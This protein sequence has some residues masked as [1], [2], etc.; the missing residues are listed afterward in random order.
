MITRAG[1][2]PAPNI[3]IDSQEGSRHQRSALH[4]MSCSV[5]SSLAI[6]LVIL[7][8]VFCTPSATAD[9]LVCKQLLIKRWVSPDGQYDGFI[10]KGIDCLGLDCCGC[11]ALGDD[12]NTVE[13]TPYPIPGTYD[14]QFVVKMS[15]CCVVPIA[16][17]SI[18]ETQDA[19]ELKPDPERCDPGS[20]LACAEYGADCLGDPDE[21]CGNDALRCY[22][23][24]PFGYKVFHGAPL[25][26]DVSGDTRFFYWSRGSLGIFVTASP[27]GA[28]LTACELPKKMTFTFPAPEDCD[29]CDGE[30]QTIDV[31]LVWDPSACPCESTCS[32]ATQDCSGDGGGGSGPGSG[33][34]GGP[35]APVPPTMHPLPVIRAGNASFSPSL[36]GQI[37]YE[38]RVVA[39]SDAFGG[40]DIAYLYRIPGL[41]VVYDDLDHVFVQHNGPNNITGNIYELQ[42]RVLVKATQMEYV[43]NNTRTGVGSEYSLINGWT[44][45]RLNLSEIRLIGEDSSVLTK[46]RA[47]EAQLASGE[48]APSSWQDASSSSIYLNFEY[49]SNSL[50]TQ[51]EAH[52]GQVM[53]L[54]YDEVLYGPMGNESTRYN[55]A[56]ISNSCESCPS[57]TYEFDSELLTKVKDADSTTIAA[58]DYASYTQISYPVLTKAYRAIGTTN[59]NMYDAVYDVTGNKI[60]HY[61]YQTATNKQAVVDEFDG[62]LGGLTKRS[63]Y[64]TT[65]TGAPSGSADVINYYYNYSDDN[66]LSMEAAMP[67]DN[68]H[69]WLLPGTDDGI[70]QVT[71]YFVSDGGSN[72]ITMAS[73]GFGSL[74]ENIEAPVLSMTDVR[75]SQTI[76]EYDE[77]PNL[78]LTKTIDPQVSTVMGNVRH[79]TDYAYDNQ[80]RLTRIARRTTNGSFTYTD[81][82]YDG[83]DRA[84]LSIQDSGGENLTTAYTYDSAGRLRTAQDPRGVRRV[85]SYSTAGSLARQYTL[86][87]GSSD[88]LELTI[89]DYD[90]LGRLTRQRIAKSDGTISSPESYSGDAITTQFSY[91]VYGRR[92]GVVTDSGGLNLTT[93]Y[94]YDNLDRVVKTTTPGGIF[95][96]IDRDGRGR[97]IRQIVGATGGNS[98]TTGYEYDA[99]SNLTRVSEPSG[100]VMTYDYDGFDRRT[101]ATRSAS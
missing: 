61:N 84:T 42:N 87:T 1:Q 50:L 33:G 71:K 68:T 82:L 60:T 13:P 54:E 73:Y 46:V 80:Y 9:D 55:L 39:F 89:Y 18:I 28:E 37:P 75:G 98:L 11:D 40:Y 17:T 66:L 57:Y 74:W 41:G 56:S 63:Y 96:Q 91:D 58:Y 19:D 76:Y 83:F 31:E 53:T 69:K 3:V 77:S 95:T 49:D 32:A 27:A 85:S 16:I 51:V 65:T 94:D 15:S 26:C 48:Y 36:T 24:S 25:I 12:C 14:S 81:Y 22:C 7:I 38:A 52:H 59:F 93:T 99:N 10:D 47:Y 90:G 29:A 34:G 79:T 20:D 6:S 62:S 2:L 23:D 30:T 97:R 86:G 8:G 92:T 67:R 45:E 35:G 70:N 78:L 64:R 101:K 44:R 88:A 21:C 5:I 43:F 100:I 4:S 72:A